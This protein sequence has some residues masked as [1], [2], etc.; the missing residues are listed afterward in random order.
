[1]QSVNWG[2]VKMYAAAVH[3]FAL[4]RRSAGTD[5]TAAAREMLTAANSNGSNSS[6]QLKQL[7]QLKHL[8]LQTSNPRRS[9]A[10]AAAALPH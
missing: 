6:K 3:P 2:Y 5:R 1:M 9:D 8:K 7:K 4:Q 10:R